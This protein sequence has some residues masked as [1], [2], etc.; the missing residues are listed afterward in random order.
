MSNATV[1]Q[2]RAGR[3]DVRSADGTPLAVWVDGR[4]PALVL[5]HGSIA[6]HT[7]FDPFVEVLRDNFTTFSMDR[8]GF[9]ASRDGAVYAIE[10]DFEDVA[11]VVDAVAG[12][13]G[14]PV[15][16]WGHSYGANCAM[17]GA[18]GTGN[19]HH[20]VLYEPSLGLTYPPGSIDAIEDSLARGDREGAIVAVL[21]DILDMT[22]D[23]IDGFRSNSLWPVRVAAAHTVPRECRVEDTW[24]YAPGQ[25]DGIN[26]PTILLTGSDSVPEIVKAT[27]QAAAAIPNARVRVLD[28]HAHFAHKT[29]P[30]MVDAIIQDF[31]AS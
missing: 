1:A 10:R 4:G 6:D 31:I 30:A 27:E 24:V 8:R 23:E 18:A 5:V 7:T 12:R 17:G 9:G 19:V 22:D 2:G 20:L 28:G 15:A 14:G 21:R 11:A 25:F 16:L 13:T 3:F 26:A 29:H